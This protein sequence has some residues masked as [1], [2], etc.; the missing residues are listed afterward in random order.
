M[1]RTFT[2][3]PAG[4]DSIPG[5]VIPETQKL[6]IDASLLNIQYYIERIKG[7]VEQSRKR[8]STLSYTL[9]L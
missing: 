1:V 7:K 6:A 8:N 2:N 4:R 5:R 3:G 9:V